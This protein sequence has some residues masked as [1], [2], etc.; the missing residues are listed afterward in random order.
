[1]G[2]DITTAT[3][4]AL[5]TRSSEAWQK[6]LRRGLGSENGKPILMTGI[7]ISSLQAQSLTERR[8]YL[9]R[10]LTAAQDERD[11]AVSIGKLLSAFAI[12]N[13][14][15]GAAELRGEAYMDAVADAPAWAVETVRRAIIQGKTD[16]DM[17][18]AP[19]PPQVAA[20]VRM[21]LEP[22]EREKRE[23]D[24]ILQIA[25]STPV[26]TRTEEAA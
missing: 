19:T 24:A 26:P 12:G 20:K 1:M 14:S 13:Q 4:D 6:Q 5:T 2:T 18:F 11:K 22:I 8:G 3:G 16:L 25:P 17:R 21:L 15:D 7:T 23:I 10:R 9:E